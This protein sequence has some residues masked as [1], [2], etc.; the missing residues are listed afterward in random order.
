[1]QKR[2]KTKQKNP[3]TYRRPYPPALSKHSGGE[4]GEE[5]ELAANG[6]QLMPPEHFFGCEATS[7][8]AAFLL[9]PQCL[10]PGA[11]CHAAGTTAAL[12]TT[13]LRLKEAAR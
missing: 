9:L 3:L 8:Q 11:S 13:L 1:M 5:I 6:I 10:L 4:K 2:T 12:R 7:V